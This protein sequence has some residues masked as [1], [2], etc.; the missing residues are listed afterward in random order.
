MENKKLEKKSVLK[1]LT[2]GIAAMALI[3]CAFVGGTFARY[4]S[5]GRVDEGGGANISDWFI[6]EEHGEGTDE[7]M[8]TISPLMGE[9][10]TEAR[11][12]TVAEGGEI[13][14]LTNRG[15][16]NAYI[17]LNIEGGLQA[18]G[19]TF[20]DDGITEFALE[21]DTEYT[22]SVDGTKYKWDTTNNRPLVYTLDEATNTYIY[23]TPAEWN[24]VSLFGPDGGNNVLKVGAV[25]V[26]TVTLAEGDGKIE[27]SGDQ[28][29]GWTFTLKPGETIAVKIGET[30]WFS[31]FTDENGDNGDA[32]D[33]WIGEN[34]ARV[35]YKFTWTAVQNSEEPA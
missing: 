4:E 13:L 3:S 26:E 31:D 33:T 34:I 16:V 15:S 32:R 35:G 14:R 30:T 12:H 7:M 5:S 29:N 18:F 27:V 11:F 24:N 22:S 20:T 6:D 9:Y 28:T 21:A 10:D 8:F 17:T 23:E 19:K 25:S 1:K 2:I